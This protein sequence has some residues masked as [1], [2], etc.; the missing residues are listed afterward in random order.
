[1]K[2]SEPQPYID[3]DPICMT[4]HGSGAVIYDIFGID[5][6]PVCARKA[7]MEYRT[8]YPSNDGE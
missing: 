7:E 6:C 3:R 8:V 5:A 4:C 1:M 2:S